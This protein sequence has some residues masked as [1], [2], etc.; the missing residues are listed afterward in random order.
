M[1]V[2]HFADIVFDHSFLAT[3]HPRAG[4]LFAAVRAEEERAQ[5]VAKLV[6]MKRMLQLVKQASASDAPPRVPHSMHSPT[7]TTVD[8]DARVWIFANGCSL[9]KRA[10]GANG[11]F[12]RLCVTAVRAV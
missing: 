5:R 3:P 2:R 9:E 11:S 1:T 4:N 8:I 7:R 12:P 6:R 10:C